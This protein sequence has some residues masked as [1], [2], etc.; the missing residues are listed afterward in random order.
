MREKGRAE[1]GGQRNK[2]SL[3]AGWLKA[4]PMGKLEGYHSYVLNCGNEPRFYP[5]ASIS[6]WFGAA[7][8]FPGGIS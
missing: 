3:V 5:P 7:E 1:E 2:R 4:D 8:K 6:H